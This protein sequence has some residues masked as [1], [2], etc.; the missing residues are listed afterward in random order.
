MK[1]IASIFLILYLFNPLLAR[2]W[3]LQE[4]KNNISK[5]GNTWIADET[6]FSRLPKEVKKLFFYKDETLLKLDSTIPVHAN[7]GL[8]APDHIDY[9]NFDGKNYMTPVKDFGHG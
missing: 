6:F 7:K 8:K 9:R 3:T 5:N 2:E 4:T 1:L